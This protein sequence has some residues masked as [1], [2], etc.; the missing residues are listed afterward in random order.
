M[1]TAITIFLTIL[2][3][4]AVFVIGVCVGVAAQRLQTEKNNDTANPLS[5]FN[6]KDAIKGGELDA[7]IA[8]AIRRNSLRNKP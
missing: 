7:E 1:I 4:I 5:G 8:R 6:L 3:S 2:A